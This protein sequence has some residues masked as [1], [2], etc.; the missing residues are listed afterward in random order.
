MDILSPSMALEKLMS[1]RH[2]CFLRGIVGNRRKDSPNQY[3]PEDDFK[4]A[5]RTLN[6][7]Y[8]QIRDQNRHAHRSE[9]RR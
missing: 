3:H 2:Y 7:L 6:R 8:V 4:L 9:R 1:V 5:F